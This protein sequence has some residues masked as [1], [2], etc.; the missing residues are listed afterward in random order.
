[1]TTNII[2]SVKPFNFNKLSV[3]AAGFEPAT[4]C[5]Q[6]RRDEPGY[7]TPRIYFLRTFITNL[8]VWFFRSFAIHFPK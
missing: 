2:H 7:A 5:S 4:S 6:S 3:G 8:P 1:M